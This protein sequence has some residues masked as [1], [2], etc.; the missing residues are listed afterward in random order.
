MMRSCILVLVAVVVFGC[1][2][3]SAPSPGPDVVAGRD[4]VTSEQAQGALDGLG[5][6]DEGAEEASTLLDPGAGTEDGGAEDTPADE[7][8]D[9]ASEAMDQGTLESGVDLGPEAPTQEMTEEPILDM[10]ESA[11]ELALDVAEA[12]DPAQDSPKQDEVAVAEDV[13]GSGLEVSDAGIA[14]LLAPTLKLLT[15]S[16]SL[17]TLVR[18]GGTC[19]NG[20]Q[21]VIFKN[22]S[23][24]GKPVATLSR[25]EFNQQ[26]FVTQ[27]E[28]G[29]TTYFSAF[30]T[31]GQKQSACSN[32]VTYVHHNNKYWRVT[33]FDDFKGMQPGE[34][35]LCYSM[36]PQ[37]IGEYLTGLYECPKGEAHQG[38]AALNKCN[39]TILRQ[40]NWMAKEYG[41]DKNMTNGFSPLE[42]RVE[43]DTD[44]GVLIL[45]ANAYKWDGTRLDPGK[46]APLEKTCLQQSQ[47]NW[48]L[49]EANTPVDCTNVTRYECVWNANKN[50]CPI[51]SGAVYSKR[52][53]AYKEGSSTVAKQRGFTQ[54]YG[55]FEVKAKLPEGMGSFPAHW[56]LPQNGSWP[57][58]GEIDIMEADRY[59]AKSYQTYHTGYCEGTEEHYFTNHQDC[60]NKGG[61]RYHLAKGGFLTYRQGSF[62][63]D[64][65]TFAVEWSPDGLAYYTD[66]ILVTTIANGELN[67][68]NYTSPHRTTGQARPM[69]I[70]FLDFFIILNQTVHND[71]WGDIEPLNFV[72]HL[73]VIDYVKVYGMCQAPS[74]FCKDG[75]Y[76]DG[77]DN[78]CHPVG[79]DGMTKAYASPCGLKEKVVPQPKPMDANTFYPC[80]TPCPFG[81]WYDSKNCQIFNSPSGR[82]VFFYPDMQGNMYYVTDGSPDGNCKDVVEGTVLPV[83][84]Y[85]GAN[86]YL[87]KTIPAI[88]GKYFRWGS[89][90]PN[91]FYYQ[92]FCKFE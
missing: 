44:N 15:E 13:S 87:D 11:P 5:P 57:E 17:D 45:S 6:E 21:V 64:Y 30:A 60:L 35:P 1:S 88:W 59:A 19:P 26:G 32:A 82:E 75:Y 39:W 7:G 65:H 34:D 10:D 50:N 8:S 84:K 48:L 24:A 38:L 76:F 69:N 58:A 80:T 29:S 47:K 2:T 67:Y 42:V 86:C 20:T 89:P 56:L 22:K 73:H 52:F 79:D 33:F 49:H 70:P 36:P 37:C 43:P 51:M 91:A 85:D 71:L 25:E 78:L 63:F 83:G 90:K 62:A 9:L 4:M 31:D 81:G 53:S 27:V 16:P 77:N 66:G 12:A 46:L 23:C 18:L 68:G 28:E 41:P 40:P 92:P 72:T 3:S 14:I 55:F 61:F 74:D 54:S